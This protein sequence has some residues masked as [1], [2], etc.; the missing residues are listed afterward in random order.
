MAT[1]YMPISEEIANDKV[2]LA[3]EAVKH[4]RNDFEESKM[5]YDSSWISYTLRFFDGWPTERLIIFR[6]PV[7]SKFFDCIRVKDGSTG[8]VEWEALRKAGIWMGLVPINHQI[9]AMLVELMLIGRKHVE[10]LS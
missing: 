5:E 1:K 7:S 2:K 10:G 6:P 3:A 9:E 4:F 8:A